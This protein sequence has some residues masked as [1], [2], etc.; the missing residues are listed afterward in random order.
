MRRHRTALVA[1]ATAAWLAALAVIVPTLLWGANPIVCALGLWCASAVLLVWMLRRT[2][3]RNI[4]FGS[5]ATAMT[6]IAVTA[7]AFAATT[8]VLSPQLQ[9]AAEQAWVVKARVQLTSDVSVGQ[10]L[11]RW[12]NQSNTSTAQ[13]RLLRITARHHSWQMSAPVLLVVS[14]PRSS[15]AR[16]DAD[17]HTGQH[18]AA[19]IPGEPGATFDMF[20]RVLPGDPWRKQAAV[21]RVIDA[22]ELVRDAPW[23]SRIASRWREGL[24]AAAHSANRDAAG[25]LPSLTL[26][27][28]SGN[29]DELTAD[30]RTSGLA[31]LAAVSGANVSI[32]LL[33][34][35]AVGVLVGLRR[36][37]LAV[38]L[39]AALTW[40]VVLARPSPSV[41]RAAGMGAVMLAPMLVGWRRTPRGGDPVAVL[42]VAVA[43]LLVVDPWLA[44]S[45]GF[46][47]SAVATAALVTLSGPMMRWLNHRL[48][49]GYQ[50]ELTAHQNFRLRAA[51]VSARLRTWF[52]AAVSVT[53]CAQLAVSPLLI[54]MGATVSWVSV[55]ANVLAEPAVPLATISGL[56]ASGVSQVWPAAA[57]AVAVPGIW[58]TS[59]IARVAHTTAD[60][61]RSSTEAIVWPWQNQPVPDSAIA[62]L[63]NVGQGTGLIIRTSPGEALVIDTGPEPSAM[64]G[65]LRRM[66]IT[67]VPLLVL[68]H[69]HADHIG[70]FA[71]VLAHRHI[72]RLLVSPLP[73]PAAGRQW[74]LAQARSQGIPVTVGATGVQMSIGAVKVTALSP[75]VLLTSTPSP[76]NDTC[77]AVE[78]DLPIAQ[79]PAPVRILA[80]CDLEFAGQQELLRDP[81][82]PQGNYDIALVP[83]HGSNRQVPAFAHWAH[84]RIA[85]IPVGA[86][87]DYGH[88][89]ASALNL[90]GSLAGTE[91]ARTDTQGDVVVQFDARGLH[92]EHSYSEG[93]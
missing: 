77:V 22:P 76:P 71:G 27:D 26:G 42:C 19:E 12:G 56:A 41:L 16:G 90:W 75:E 33:A 20:V 31:H 72:G 49:G 64:D 15:P 35:T 63:C 45:Y 9:Q 73:E 58:A 54:S 24:R 52:I 87:N 89:A 3:R 32:V 86:G 74:V 43:L 82:L 69:F 28:T 7:S 91:L 8:A 47:L 36:R 17:N 81:L 29:S 67:S 53:V 85:L 25:L 39:C 57:H 55:P 65:C 4:S 83:H 79:R 14:T 78:V 84:P 23:F 2:D 18:I 92:L 59:W 44:L 38:F 48:P 10:R 6:C 13:A 40:F 60:W 34:V 5:A 93:P 30:M 61:H 88:P 68:S 51:G 80:P 46:A 11:D 66:R 37:F 1:C 21:L 50:R 62:M 70:G